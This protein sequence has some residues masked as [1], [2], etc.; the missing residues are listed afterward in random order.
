LYYLIDVAIVNSYIFYKETMSQLAFRS[1][2]ANE[3]I[4]DFCS[5]SK[6]GPSASPKVVS[7]AKF[8]RGRHGNHVMQFS[9]VTEHMLAASMSWRYAYCSTQNKEKEAN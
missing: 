3:L 2:L 9:N 1:S 4:G 5:K 6:R 7:K 8:R